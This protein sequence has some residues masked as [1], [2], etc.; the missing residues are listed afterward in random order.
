MTIVSM[1]TPKKMYPHRCHLVSGLYFGF[2]SPS[3]A[4]SLEAAV[5]AFADSDSACAVDSSDLWDE[6]AAKAAD[7]K[8]SSPFGEDSFLFEAPTT[9]HCNTIVRRRMTF[10]CAQLPTTHLAALAAEKVNMA[11]LSKEYLTVLS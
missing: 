1:L 11:A 6:N 4:F 9:G 10:P 8:A 2:S 5:V 3:P 7:L